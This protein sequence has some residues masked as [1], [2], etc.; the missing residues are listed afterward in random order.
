MLALFCA[1]L[2][3]KKIPCLVSD[4]AVIAVQFRLILADT[5][6]L[7]IIGFMRFSACLKEYGKPTTGI[8]L[9][10]FYKCKSCMSLPISLGSMVLKTSYSKS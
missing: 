6:P 3:A 2:I 9:N 8:S 10:T 4:D 5:I 1:L 7:F